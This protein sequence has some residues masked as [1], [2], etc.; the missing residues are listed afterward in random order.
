MSSKKINVVKKAMRNS[1][2]NIKTYDI[3][4]MLN[5]MKTVV[6]NT[7]RVCTEQNDNN[8]NTHKRSKSLSSLQVSS[9]QLN[10]ENIKHAMNSKKQNKTKIQLP[11]IKTKLKHKSK[12]FHSN[13]SLLS[14]QTST[15]DSFLQLRNP[16]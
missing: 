5:N 7:H 9:L 16:N 4:T 11:K 1:V 6:N 15:L 12:P 14:T 3:Y 10:K 2:V 13:S 8:D